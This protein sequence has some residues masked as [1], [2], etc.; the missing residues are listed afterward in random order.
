MNDV[1]FYRHF[2][3]VDQSGRIL[4]GWSDGPHPKRDKN[5][6]LCLTDKGG[7][8][9]RLAVGGEENPRLANEAGIPLYRW[10]GVRVIPRTAEEIR[11]DLAAL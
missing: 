10:D 8:Q 11:A 3:L 4:D 1:F 5:E 2:I 7:Y 9:F 6:G